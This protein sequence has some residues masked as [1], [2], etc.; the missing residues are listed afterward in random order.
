MDSTGRLMR[1]WR[2]IFTV[3]LFPCIGDI[4]TDLLVMGL[5]VSNVFENRED[6]C[7]KGWANEKR[8]IGFLRCI[9][10]HG[11]I[12]AKIPISKLARR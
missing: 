2:K 1:L 7:M 6:G 3:K 11:V 5:N 9:L 10:S 4:R 8:G 12:W